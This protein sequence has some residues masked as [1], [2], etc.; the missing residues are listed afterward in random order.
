MTD[1]EWWRGNSEAQRT[2]LRDQVVDESGRGSSQLFDT[3]R[4][5]ASAYRVMQGLGSREDA[6]LVVAQLIADCEIAV[7]DASV[8]L[9]AEDDLST[10]AA[11]N[12]HM[13]ARVA[14]GILAHLNDY[15]KRAATAQRDYN[16]EPHEDAN[17][18]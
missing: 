14:A 3:M 11:K 1:R 4:L 7:R 8:L 5:G 18:R 16:N 13:R 6:A 2:A 9:L 12:Q 15:V 10:P 17:G